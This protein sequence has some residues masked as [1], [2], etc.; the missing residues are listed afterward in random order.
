MQIESL[1]LPSGL[2]ELDVRI[3]GQGYYVKFNLLGDGREEAGAY[4]ALKSHLD[5]GHITPRQYIDVRV[6]GKGYYK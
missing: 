1:T 5:A 3:K 2:S 6:E 4:L